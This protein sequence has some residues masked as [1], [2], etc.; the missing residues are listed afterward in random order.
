MA[1]VSNGWVYG[2]RTA[3][4]VA[5]NL[6]SLV[7][8]QAKPMGSVDT[9]TPPPSTPCLGFLIDI[10]ITPASASVSS[11]GVISVYL[12]QS[13]DGGTN[14]TDRISPSGT[15]NI[16][17]SLKNAKLVRTMAVNAVSGTIAVFQDDF[18]LPVQCP[19]PKWSLVILNSTGA[20]LP[21]SGHS[22]NYTPVYTQSG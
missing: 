6:N 7:S 17:S 14:Y 8:T 13:L 11:T 20:D 16:A 10:S 18:F 22:I 2:T 15:S 1:N 19:A 5:S 21:S 9:P 3:F 12:I 4:S